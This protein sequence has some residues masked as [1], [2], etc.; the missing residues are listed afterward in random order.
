MQM[1]LKNKKE[2]IYIDHTRRLHI[3]L[4]LRFW[5]RITGDCFLSFSFARV[6]IL[7]AF[8]LETEKRIGKKK[9]R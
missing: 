9:R 5:G 3:K 7:K 8:I 6:T 2:Y 1:K 4:P